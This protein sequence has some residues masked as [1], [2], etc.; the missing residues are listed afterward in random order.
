MNISLRNTLSARW[1]FGCLLA[2]VL[3]AATARPLS[4]QSTN[5]TRLPFTMVLAPNGVP[6]AN[7]TVPNNVFALWFPSGNTLQT[8]TPANPIG[9]GATGANLV[10]EHIHIIYSGAVGSALSVQF[11][12]CYD[13]SL[14]G[15]G[16]SAQVCPYML[17]QTPPVTVAAPSTSVSI[18]IKINIPTASYS[19][20]T[21]SLS[22]FA[23]YVP[24]GPWRSTL[25]SGS[26]VI[27]Q[28]TS[29]R[30]KDASSGSEII[31][32]GAR[33]PE[34]HATT[35]GSTRSRTNGHSAC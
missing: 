16:Q 4:A 12:A 24:G 15:T 18:P 21:A 17:F 1:A 7:Y 9:A 33:N 28:D 26:G 32:M 11:Q 31:A 20:V 14:V 23:F 30:S 3:V 27:S 34:R 2:G 10:L 6:V 35:S 13:Q 25:P 22:N 29:N 5:P 8:W 19:T